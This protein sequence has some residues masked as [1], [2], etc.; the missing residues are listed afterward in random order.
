MLNHAFE[1]D[2]PEGNPRKEAL[3]KFKETYLRWKDKVDNDQKEY[4]LKI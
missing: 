3:Q 1:H 2:I 4:N